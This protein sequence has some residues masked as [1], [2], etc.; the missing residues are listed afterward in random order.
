MKRQNG[1]QVKGGSKKAQLILLAGFLLALAII[2]V[3]VMLG[4]IFYSQSQGSSSSVGLSGFTDRATVQDRAVEANAPQTINFTN[5]ESK[6]EGL[7]TQN[8]STSLEEDVENLTRVV[9][10]IREDA[11]IVNIRVLDIKTHGNFSWLAGNDEEMALPGMV[12]NESEKTRKDVDMALVIDTTGS[13]GLDYTSGSYPYY[14]RHRPPADD[15]DA[16]ADSGFSRVSRRNGT[17]DPAWKP[18]TP[19]SGARYCDETR[20]ETGIGFP[21]S[22]CEIDYDES[23][24]SINTGDFVVHTGYAVDADPY[25]SPLYYVDEPI[26]EV[27]G[28]SCGGGDCDY[29]LNY[30]LPDIIPDYHDHSGSEYSSHGTNVDDSEIEKIDM[31][32]TQ[33]NVSAPVRYRL[34][35]PDRLYNTKVES[36]W[37]MGQ[38]NT[39]H[40]QIGLIEYSSED[41]EGWYDANTLVGLAQATGGQRDN[42]NTSTD[43]LDPRG[44]T[45]IASGIEEA[46]T[47][48]T[49]GPNARSNASKHIVLHT[50]G[51]NSP[52]SQ[53]PNSGDDLDQDTID[54]ANV[55]ASEN[56]TIHTL[57][58]G[59]N[60]DESLMNQVANITGGINA[61][62]QPDEIREKFKEILAEIRRTSTT[63]VGS[64]TS[65]INKIHKL[66]TNV[67]EF[68]DAGNYSLTITQNNDRALYFEIDNT[69]PSEYQFQISSQTHPSIGVS[70]TVSQEI[71]DSYAYFNFRDGVA[72]VPGSSVTDINTDTIFDDLNSAN[73]P[74]G[75]RANNTPVNAT[76]RN[77][78]ANGT[79]VFEFEPLSGDFQR[80]DTGN[81]LHFGADNCPCGGDRYSTA[82]IREAVLEV[83]ISGPDGEY[84]KRITVDAEELERLRGT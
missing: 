81:E 77:A 42:I 32:A 22:Y 5:N 67:T 3:S 56:I 23:T 8:V 53:T 74:V 33:P 83:T 58:L 31:S 52:D 6:H 45:N 50:D 61:T 20:Q 72:D 10:Q 68:Q 34:W 4:G 39:T 36:K 78:S 71:N 57:A 48:L 44:G 28:V 27:T 24:T 15:Y 11:N 54:A 19:A 76:L 12:L 25:D 26:A 14:R 84:T 59:Q 21:G 66:E 38:L 55:A 43:K 65:S 29:N 62:A 40:D 41:G 79:F 60:A 1:K 47:M 49:S 70:D 69:P 9:E 46:I 30:L 80:Y 13:M 63:I 75:F 64:D 51:Q 16:N 37:L 35:T 2:A 17:G 82:R 7:S 18:F 73:D